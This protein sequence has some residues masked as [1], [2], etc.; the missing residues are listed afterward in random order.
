M[1]SKK[2]LFP[3][4]L[5]ISQH[6]RSL[7]DMD[8]HAWNVDRI[9]LDRGVFYSYLDAFHTHNVQLGVT[10]R[11]IRLAVNGE[12]SPNAISFVMIINDG[13]IIQ[14]K[15]KMTK[16]HL[17]V[18]ENVSKLRIASQSAAVRLRLVIVPVIVMSP[19]SRS[20]RSGNSELMPNVRTAAIGFR[21]D[22]LKPLVVPVLS[23]SV[24]PESVG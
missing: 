8:F 7:K 2:P 23:L 24:L 10:H 13:T 17:A 19:S 12:N 22:T 4:G 6:I 16:Y 20:M 5:I 21:T 18:I 11:S 14:Q 3:A 9:Q 15:Q 1:H